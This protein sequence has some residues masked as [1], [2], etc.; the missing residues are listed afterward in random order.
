MALKARCAGLASNKSLR[1]RAPHRRHFAVSVEEAKY[2]LFHQSEMSRIMSQANVLPLRPRLVLRVGFAGNCDLPANATGPLTTALADLFE[3]I[4]RQLVE[5]A[6]GRPA[7]PDHPPRISEFFAQE[8]P[9]LRLITGLAEGADTLAADAFEQVAAD[10]SLAPHFGAEL[11][12]VLPFDVATYRRSRNPTFQPHFDRLAARCAYILTLDGLY[13]KPQPDSEIAKSRRGR[14]YRGQSTFLLRQSDLLIAAANPDV[15]GLAG[16]T[17]ETARS[18]LAFDLPVIFIHTDTRQVWLI[19]PGE[20]LAE[21]LAGPSLEVSEWKPQLRGWVRNLVTGTSA[22]PAPSPPGP[23]DPATARPQHGRLLLEEFFHADSTPPLVPGPHGTPIPVGKFREQC[24]PKFEKWFRPHDVPGPESDPPLPPYE[25]YRRRASRLN[26]T[27][28][29]LYRGAFVLNYALA[30]IAVILAAL[31][32]VVLS[33]EKAWITKTAPPDRP[34]IA[35]VRPESE[36]ANKTEPPP[37]TRPNPASEEGKDEPRPS[38]WFYLTLMSLGALKLA[39]LFW[40]LRNTEQAN[41][42]DWNDKAVDYRYLAERLRTMYYLP[43]IGSFQPPAVAT[44]Q[45]VAR[46]VR[47]SAVDWLFDAI[48]RSISPASLPFACKVMIGG[49]GGSTIGQSTVIH[50]EATKLLD[51]VR[52][53]WVAQ[54]A[55]Y[56]HRN[57]LTM[58]GMFD[59]CEVFGRRLSKAVLYVVIADLVLVLFEMFDRVP[60]Y[61]DLWK[62][63]AARLFLFLAAMLPAAVASFNAIRFQSECRR[64]AERSA[65]IRT[66]LRGHENRDELKGGR[67]AEADALASRIAHADPA[68][69][70]GVWSLEVLRLT[71]TIASD[72][73]HEVTEWSVLY[74]K[75]VPEPG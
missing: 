24:W 23:N 37:A 2:E 6:P 66:I 68:S 17:M 18:A 5:I 48:V 14:A 38:F 56:H 26:G 7:P 40:I 42:G 67:W 73:V 43:R 8:N 9:L 35:G 33:T 28:S 61:A 70:R 71:E 55:V 13:E 58:Q 75:E 15:P 54:Q 25:S 50:L 29:A 59:F 72:F 3:T 27:F 21:V 30:V 32:L 39:I 34:V 57:A 63:L 16:G 62:A 74:A 52:D 47:Q 41:K 20:S 46:A 69:D 60:D 11:A 4:A 53:Q 64:L 10:S 1:K 45:Y 36:V 19:A 51:D 22:V 65:V 44:P 12:A 31:S 49:A